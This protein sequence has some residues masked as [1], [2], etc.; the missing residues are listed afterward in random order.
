[1]LNGSYEMMESPF[2]LDS[3][4]RRSMGDGWEGLIS[5]DDPDVEDDEGYELPG[6]LILPS[7]NM[8]NRTTPLPPTSPSIFTMPDSVPSQVA[9]I[10]QDERTVGANRPQGTNT[11]N[12]NELRLLAT[13]LA[14]IGFF[15]VLSLTSTIFVLTERNALQSTV[16]R[17][18]EQV[19]LLQQQVMSN[20][21]NNNMAFSNQYIRSWPPQP[22]ES[23][24]PHGETTTT[25]TK[26]RNKDAVSTPPPDV[27]QN[28]I[29]TCWVKA[30][31]N[32]TL[33]KCAV[34]SQRT[35]K[36]NLNLMGRNLNKMGRNLW[37][38][39]EE[40]IVMMKDIKKQYAESSSA[41]FPDMSPSSSNFGSSTKDNNKNSSKTVERAQQQQENVVPTSSNKNELL[42]RR[43]GKAATSVLTDV[44]FVSAVGLI[45]VGSFVGSV[46]LPSDEDTK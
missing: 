35:I 42:L 6:V 10:G 4:A 13:I 41:I 11:H 40:F 46:L 17:L 8:M 23:D 28:S 36:R 20:N 12:N 24:S 45:V 18:E 26:P 29:D 16:L 2:F 9:S 19:R 1:M 38:A 34:S 43:I 3:E 21:N 44:A 37:R 15:F 25:T 14:F 31:A 39:Q 33:G 30:H 22:T 27:H 7:A 5:D 32:F